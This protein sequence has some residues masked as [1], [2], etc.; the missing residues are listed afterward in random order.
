MPRGTNK[1]KKVRWTKQVTKKNDELTEVNENDNHAAEAKIRKR[2]VSSDRSM[3][4]SS[5]RIKS[6]VVA[7]NAEQVFV[8]TAETV[9]FDEGDN[10]I[11]I[12]LKG[13]DQTAFP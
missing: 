12:E 3:D 9:Q 5:K 2:S 8:H 11:Q 4:R 7:E 6:K 1:V 13:R 10:I